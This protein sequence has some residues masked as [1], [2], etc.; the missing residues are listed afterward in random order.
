MHASEAP[1]GSTLETKEPFE[2][3]KLLEQAQG[4]MNQ[5]STTINQVQGTMNDVSGH[6]DTTL[7]TATSTIKNVNGVVRMCAVEKVPLGCC[8]K[9]RRPPRT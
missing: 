2:I 6:L 4:I 8:L 1:A 5:T 3:S 7:D 9:I